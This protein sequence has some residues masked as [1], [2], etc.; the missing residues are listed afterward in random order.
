M[1]TSAKVRLFHTE[2]SPH[3]FSMDAGSS[4]ASSNATMSAAGTTFNPTKRPLGPGENLVVSDFSIGDIHRPLPISIGFLRSCGP[5]L[6]AVNGKFSLSFPCE[7][8][9]GRRG[10]DISLDSCSESPSESGTTKSDMRSDSS[11]RSS[12][13]LEDE[14]VEIRLFALLVGLAALELILLLPFPKVEM[15]A[16]VRGS[17]SELTW[18]TFKGLC[19]IGIWSSNDEFGRMRRCLEV[20]ILVRLP[21]YLGSFVLAGTAQ[22][23]SRVASSGSSSSLSVNALSFAI[24]YWARVSAK[25]VSWLGGEVDC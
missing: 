18:A 19:L 6:D 20:W 2:F 13:A 11:S 9:P 8:A 21:G 24:V 14:T 4:K 25:V 17:K 15:L 23:P 22:V 1:G 16:F 5:V 12:D 7:E 3:Y 10:L